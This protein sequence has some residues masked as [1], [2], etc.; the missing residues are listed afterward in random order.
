MVVA[1]VV[2]VPLLLLNAYLLTWYLP[3]LTGDRPAG[4]LLVCALTV[5]SAVCLGLGWARR[6]GKG[7]WVWPLAAAALVVASW[8]S[9][10]SL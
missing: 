6:R 9:L 10:S 5:A 7:R 8:P 3:E 4:W 2:L 1:S